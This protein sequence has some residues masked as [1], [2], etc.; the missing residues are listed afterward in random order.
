MSHSSNGTPL[1]ALD[2]AR[3]TPT[4]PKDWPYRVLPANIASPEDYTAGYDVVDVRTDKR[5]IHFP[6]GDLNLAQRFTD[7]QNERFAEEENEACFGKVGAG[8]GN[9]AAPDRPRPPAYSPIPAEMK[10][11]FGEMFEAEAKAVHDSLKP[12]PP[13]AHASLDA[14]ICDHDCPCRGPVDPDERWTLAHA[15]LPGGFA[16]TDAG[17]DDPGT[18]DATD[19]DAIERDLDTQAALEAAVEEHFDDLAMIEVAGQKRVDARLERIERALEEANR[20]TGRKAERRQRVKLIL[21]FIAGL[22]G[23][24]SAGAGI[25]WWAL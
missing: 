4:R 21:A 25:A 16:D 12:V 8:D 19:Y 10:A 1:T 6:L 18:L 13:E 14:R 17:L 24:G 7:E 23:G 15:E 9:G 5:L 3:T 2:F 11:T 20:K 22:I